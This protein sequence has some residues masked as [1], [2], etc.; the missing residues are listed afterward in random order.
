MRFLLFICCCFF[1]LNIFKEIRLH[2]SY[3]LFAK[4]FS[5][6]KKTNYF[7]IM[8]AAVV[9]LCFKGLLTRARLFKANDVVS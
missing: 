6:K 1:F 9:N 8:S 4:L 3:E 5:Q 2:I 7:R